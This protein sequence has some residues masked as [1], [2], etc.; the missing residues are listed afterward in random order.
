[1][2]RNGMNDP[3]DRHISGMTPSWRK[4]AGMFVILAMIMV[5]GG[6][7]MAMSDHIARLPFLAELLVYL[8]A[9]LIWIA[10]LRP[11]LQWMETGRFKA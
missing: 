1:M 4:P 8:V 7:I 10:P 11:L 3:Q 9:G 2:D 5:L 6:V